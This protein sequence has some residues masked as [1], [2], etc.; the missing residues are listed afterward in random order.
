M[1]QS[2]HRPDYSLLAT[3]ESNV[4]SNAFTDP[5]KI[6]GVSSL[7]FDSEEELVWAGNLSGHITSFYYN[8]NNYDEYKTMM[9]AKYTSFHLDHESDTRD[10]LTCPSGVLLLTK[11]SLRLSIRRGLTLFNH[12]SELLKDMRCMALLPSGLLLM[13]GQQ[14]KM[15]ELDIE[16]AKHVRI[17][18]IGESGSVIMRQN[19]KFLCHGDPKGKVS[20][21]FKN[22]IYLF[23]YYYYYLNLNFRLHF[24]I[25]ICFMCKEN[26]KLTKVCLILMSMEIIL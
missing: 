15:I 23:I 4:G 13:A 20:L 5:S 10:V 26:F 6:C 8:Y 19:A 2:T 12:K 9:M 25:I 21:H 22:I 24:V 16:R 18:E 14:D 17:T 11:S 7:R 3:V 1:N